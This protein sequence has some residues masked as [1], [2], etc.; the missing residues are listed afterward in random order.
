[1]ALH[2]TEPTVTHSDTARDPSEPSRGRLHTGAAQLAKMLL[3]CNLGCRA[4]AHRV[5]PV[6]ALLPI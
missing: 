6:R 3:H 5:N 1:M 4:A 2:S